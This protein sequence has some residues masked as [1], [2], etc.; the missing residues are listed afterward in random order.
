[1][2]YP[3]FE[4]LSMEF[5]GET[6]TVFKAGSGP[7]V[8]VI[9]EVPGLYPEVAEFGRKVV[10]QGFTVYMPSLL[11]TPGKKMSVPYAVSSIARACVMKEFTV[12]AKGEN[13]SITLWLRALAEHAYKECGGA[14]VGAIGMCLTGGFALAMAVDPWVKAPVLSQPSLPFAVLPSQKRDLGIDKATLGT[15]QDRM[16]K[17]GLCVM[18][19]RFTKDRAVPDERF[20][21][22]REELGEN[23]LAIEIDSSKGNA[24]NI[25]RKAHSVLTNDLVPTE[26]HP[27]QEALNEVMQFFRTRLSGN[28]SPTNT[29]PTNTSP[30]KAS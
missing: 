26:G 9:H 25:S 8:I 3:D 28:T 20:A 1:M 16:K 17:E 21:A 19:L 24:H 7:A 6:R 13:S 15:V 22:L 14:G 2:P 23:F 18:G 11:G 10:A 29:S 4:Q 27:T 12:W 30:T 5:L